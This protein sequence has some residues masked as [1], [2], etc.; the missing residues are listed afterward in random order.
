MKRR[1]PFA[2]LVLLSCSTEPKP[3]QG[4]LSREKFEHVLMN[5]LLIEART[6][7]GI[8][9]DYT[10]P[11]VNAEYAE[12]FSK[13]GV[14]KAEFDSTYNAYLRQPEVLKSV[15]EKVLNDLQQQP[16]STRH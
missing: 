11:D 13:E 14:T 8:S 7:R 9:L 5:A 2:L 15:Y 3:P 1:L 4:P 10:L 12:M 16:D 6:G